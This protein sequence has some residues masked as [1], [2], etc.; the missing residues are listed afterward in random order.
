[1]SKPKPVS[2]VPLWR[3][4]DLLMKLAAFH[5]RIIEPGTG[6]WSRPFRAVLRAMSFGFRFGVSLRNHR[7]DRGTGIKR[8]PVPVISIGNLTVGGTGKTPL[9]MEFLRRLELLGVRSGVLARGYGSV[10]G[11]AND[12]E[13]MIRARFPWVGY[14][15]DSDR[16]RGGRLLLEKHGARLLIL[17]DGFQ[18]RRLHRNLDV[19][20]VDATCPFGFGYVLPRGLLRES[21]VGLRRADVVVMTRADQVSAA[22][23]LALELRLRE[24]APSAILLKCRHVVT[25][26]ERLDGTAMP[27]P[28]PGTRALLFAGLA[29]P[30]AFKAT[31]SSL[32]VEVV[33]DKW[34]PDHHPYRRDEVEWLRQTDQFPS[35]DLL[36][37]TEKDAVKIAPLYTRVPEDLGV[38]KIAIDFLESDGTMLDAVLRT[39]VQST[40]KP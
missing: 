30:E 24:L 2:L 22:Q 29:R 28:T 33:G 21:I 23:R 10:G 1:M 38:L 19:V 25:G 37:T 31:V 27:L 11:D 40:S 34:W 15:A 13:L 20:A 18:H 6:P 14:A 9:V 26:M 5:R 16:V 17:D 4:L 7:F 12:E 8:L 3:L 35:R 36:L 32:G 39:L